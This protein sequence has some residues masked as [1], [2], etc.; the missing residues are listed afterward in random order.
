VTPARALAAFIFG[1]TLTSCSSAP[2]RPPTYPVSGSVTYEGK[3]A[4]GAVVVLHPASG[5]A[6]ADRPR[7]KA[8]AT[9][10]FTL[11]TF[12]AGDGAPA[13]EYAV[14]LEWKRIDDHPEQGTAL[15]PAAYGDPKI[16]KLRATVVAG[17][18]PPLVLKLTRTP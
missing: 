10:A 2:S 9:G 7:G 17:E 13:G 5:T 4:A 16:S 12:S 11:T 3:A 18:N 14:T 6:T 1:V 15:I 8:D